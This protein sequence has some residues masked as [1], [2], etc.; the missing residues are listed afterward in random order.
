MADVLREHGF[1][2]AR[3]TAQE[4]VLAAAN[5]VERGEALDERAVDLARVGPVEAIERLERAEIGGACA[6]REVGNIAGAALQ[7]EE[8]LDGLGGAKAALVRVGQEGGQRVA[9]GAKAEVGEL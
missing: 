7:R 5:E 1:A 3:L 9:P 8:R 4:D 2:D 6:A